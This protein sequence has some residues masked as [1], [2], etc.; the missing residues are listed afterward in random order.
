M[1]SCFVGLGSLGSFCRIFE[2][3][4]LLPKSVVVIEAIVCYVGIIGNAERAS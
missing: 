3:A 4:L 2:V 1:F